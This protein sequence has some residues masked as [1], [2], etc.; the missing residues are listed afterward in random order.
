MLSSRALPSHRSHARG[1]AV[2]G[3]PRVVRHDSAR[4][5][6]RNAPPAFLR[7]PRNASMRTHAGLPRGRA[8]LRPSDQS[9]GVGPGVAGGSGPSSGGAGGPGISGGPFPSVEGGG[10]SDGGAGGAACGSAGCGCCGGYSPLVLATLAVITCPVW[11]S[12]NTTAV[13]RPPAPPRATCQRPY[14]SRRASRVKS[15][16]RPRERAYCV[17]M[18]TASSAAMTGGAGRTSAMQAVAKVSSATRS[19]L[20]LFPGSVTAPYPGPSAARTHE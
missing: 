9:V 15:I 19:S 18:F 13:S 4:P 17:A 12:S 16:T 7:R 5:S 20:M 8:E 1:V 14:P 2:A 11:P 3:G 6:A 10:G